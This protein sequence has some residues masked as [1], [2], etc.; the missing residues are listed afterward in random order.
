M[1][2]VLVRADFSDF[3]HEDPGATVARIAQIKSDQGRDGPIGPLSVLA[4]E[5]P[6]VFLS[7]CIRHLHDER[8][9]FGRAEFDGV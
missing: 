1:G 5:A 7:L 3:P 8:R 9:E 6:E 4:G 2:A